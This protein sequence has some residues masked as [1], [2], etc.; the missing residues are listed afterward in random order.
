MKVCDEHRGGLRLEVCEHR[1]GVMLLVCVVRCG[2][3]LEAC[4][5]RGGGGERGAATGPGPAARCTMAMAVLGCCFSLRWEG[6][7]GLILN[8]NPPIAAMNSCSDVVS[9]QQWIE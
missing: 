5:K 8:P 7:G 1:G 2:I 9:S 3:R 6:G 4:E